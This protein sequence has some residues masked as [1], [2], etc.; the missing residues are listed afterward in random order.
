MCF[1]ATASFVSAA[2]LVSIGAYCITRSRILP[3]QYLALALLPFLFGVQQFT[4]G[5]LWQYLDLEISENF[6]T[7][8]L[9][10]MFFSHFLWLFWIP[11][12]SYLFEVNVRRKNIFLGLMAVGGFYGASIYIPLLLNT[13]WLVVEQISNSI[14]YRAIL[15]YDDFVP[16]S[17]VRALYALI[18]MM[19][20]LLSS[21]IRLRRIGYMV[22]ISVLL[23][24]VFYGYA[25][26]S[27]WCF[28][29]AILSIYM[30]YMV[31][32]ESVKLNRKLS[33]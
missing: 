33:G 21:D 8:A 27:V 13:E 1:S 4:E 19:P 25:F 26:I 9:G 15:I 17:M 23:A 6:R 10:Y 20:L 28:F 31:L 16:R 3:K 22:A 18:I 14:N 12:I 24:A 29:A 30:A 11:F 7:T 5:L 32:S 2:T